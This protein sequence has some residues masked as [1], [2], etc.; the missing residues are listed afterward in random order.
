MKLSK[1]ML[2]AFKLVIH[3]Y[4][5][6]AQLSRKL[7]K[8]K[9]WTSEVVSELEEEGFIAKESSFSLNKSRKKILVSNSPYALK[10]RDLMIEYKTIDFSQ[11][12]SGAKLKLLVA[13]C[14]DWKTL[15]SACS[16]AEISL[17]AAR[18]ASRELVNRGILSKQQGMQKVN[19]KAWP[20]LFDFLKEYRN[21]SRLNGSVKWK[22]NNEIIFE[23]DE[24][25][26]KKGVYTGFSRYA[27]YEIKIHTIKALCYFPEK[28]LSKE[29][30]FIHSL[31][32]ID[33]SKTLYLCLVFFL[34]NKLLREKARQKAMFY[35]MHSAF[36]D[37]EKLLDS[38][39]E[40]IKTEHF[41]Q[42]DRKEFRR[43]AKMYGVKNV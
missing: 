6:I 14:F 10:L 42:F 13:L 3:D 29:D 27:D 8:S 35:D 5:T 1:P 38:K 19:S 2:Q 22:Y 4:N 28:K 32:E 9:N 24:P 31:L 18:T 26:L 25:K 16:L 20:L 15:K 21:F 34:K 39:E 12:L 37:F 11:I 23:I 36:S 41:P 40:V 33:D 7:H 30:I 17:I 43:I